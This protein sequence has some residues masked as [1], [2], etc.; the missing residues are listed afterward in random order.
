MA[1]LTAS[2]IEYLASQ[3][4]GRLATTGGGLMGSSN[5]GSETAMIP[6][7]LGSMVGAAAVLGL[8]RRQPSI[9]RV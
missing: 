5:G 7:L 3:L 4:L 9:V 1:E 8:R 6:F 2:H